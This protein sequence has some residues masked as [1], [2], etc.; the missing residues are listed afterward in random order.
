[1]KTTAIICEYNPFHKGHLLQ[2][3]QLKTQNRAVVCIMSGG[4]VQRGQPAIFD[5]YSRAKSAVLSGAD[6]VLELP[7]P[8]SCSSAEFFCQG[9]VSIANSLNIIDELYFG[10][11]CGDIELLDQ[12]SDRLIDKQFITAL[13]AARKDKQ[14]K[15][16]PFAVLREEVYYKLYGQQLPV[17]PNDIL[18][19]EYINSLKKLNSKITPVTYKREEGFSATLSRKYIEDNDNY[20]FVPQSAADIFKN[21]PIFSL[22]N[23]ESAILAFYRLA[24]AKALEKYESMTDGMA[25][26]LVKGANECGNLNQLLENLSGKSYTNAKIRRAILHGMTGVLPSMLKEKPM[27]TQVLA[28]NDNGRKLIK[29]SQKNSSVSILTKPAHFK[30]LVGKAKEQ[31]I[32]SN[33]AEKLLTLMCDNPLSAD[34][35]LKMTPFILQQNDQETSNTLNT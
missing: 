11:E 4:F 30:K 26:R 35:F 19:I 1:M 20:D 17:R 32:F 5:K 6:L 9:G 25:N 18:G 29:K 28:A 8:F 24:N 23:I 3:E 33:N 7:Y 15:E 27:Y 31:A 21:C 22:N 13:Q 16:K 10:S 34:E 12:T 2:I 14:N